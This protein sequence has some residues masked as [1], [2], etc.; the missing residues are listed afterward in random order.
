MR[1]FLDALHVFDLFVVDVEESGQLIF[2]Y[3]RIFSLFPFNSLLSFSHLITR[4]ESWR[5]AGVKAQ[6][7]LPVSLLDKTA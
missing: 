6:N 1:D 2:A 7:A 5:E 3:Y 4:V